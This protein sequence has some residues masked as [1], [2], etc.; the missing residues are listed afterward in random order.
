M[1]SEPRTSDTADTDTDTAATDTAEHRRLAQ[2]NAGSPEWRDWGPYLAERAWGS[3]REDYSDDGDAWNFFPH[4]HARSRAYRWNEDGMAGF[5]DLGQNWCLSLA[6]WNGVDPILK[7]RMFGLTGEEGNHG[8]DVKD[9]WWFTDGTPTH[10]FNSWRYHYPQVAFPYEDLLTTNKARGRHDAEYEL[11]DTG[12]FDDSKYW[13]VTVDY[14]KGGPHDLLMTV[15]VEN[16]GPETA[17][18]RVLPTLWFRNTWSWDSTKPRPSITVDGAGLKAESEATGELHLIGDHDPAPLFCDNETNAARLFGDA[19]SPAFPKDGINDHVVH[20]AASVNPAQ[21]GTKAALDY[22]LT[23]ESGATATI[24]VRLKAGSQA[25]GSDSAAGSDGAAGSDALPPTPFDTAR[26]DE[27]VALRRAE[28]DAYWAAVTPSDATPDEAQVLR[29]AMAG[30]LWSKQFYHYNVATWLTG[31]P[32]GPAPAGGRGGVRNG[33]WRHLDAHDV[34]LMPDT[35]EYPWFAA[36]DLA[37]HCVTLAHIDPEFAKAQLILLLREWYMHPNGQLPA[38]EWNFSDVN[39]PTHAWAALQVFEID[40]ARDFD[41][42]KRIFHKLLINFTWWTNNKESGDGGDLFSGGFMGLDNIAPLD[43]SALPASVGTI[44]QADS[45]AWMGNYALDLLQ[46]A[47]VLADH[48][49]SYQDIATT[50]VEHFLAIALAANS[51]GM[52]DDDDAFF[53]DILH[54]ADGRDVPLK[55]R[56]L[57]GLVPVVA[58]L[59]YS[60]EQID[61]LPRFRERLDWVLAN[62][63]DYNQFVHV[64]E[65]ASERTTL[66]ALVPPDRLIRMLSHVFDETGMLS[67][68]GIRG[69]SAWHRDHPFVVDVAGTSASVDYE[70]AESTTALFGGNSNWRGPIW[71][72]LNVL[73]ING[74]RAN[75]LH[76]TTGKTVEFPVGTGTQLSLADAAD[77]L[78]SR[79]ISLFVPDASGRRPSDAR[80]A[81]LSADPRWKPYL[82]FYE[83]FDG[84]TGQGLG[85]S[86]QTGWTAAVAHLILKRGPRPAAG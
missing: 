36:W 42:L 58:S 28:A 16:A 74:L 38:Y 17:T 79:L 20:G 15:T 49:D 63:P 9:Y 52:W 35:W 14:A 2:A 85:A 3:V 84:D 23:V 26:F 68:H 40:G 30:L 12:V 7:E 25:A 50:F 31:D 48:D 82:F 11:V 18:I 22:A 46:I 64:S 34:I 53:Y 43:R 69:I 56:S 80:Y 5:S 8:E 67:G 24:R 76:E 47:L 61:A 4:D 57:V 37:F 29:Q 81:L 70:P 75:D 39:P 65:E 73:L 19:T 44:E 77:E 54:Q 51:S 41:F 6:V 66:L 72:P 60:D 71:F 1:P 86:H 21:T 45:T 78:S 32:A 27:V 10:S 62:H 55:V 59:V 13:V 33:N 83:Y